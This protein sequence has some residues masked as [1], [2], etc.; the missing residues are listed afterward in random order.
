MVR[1]GAVPGDPAGRAA[2]D[3]V[4]LV[5]HGVQCGPLHAEQGP[6]VRLGHA[7]RPQH[8]P[9]PRHVRL[10]TQVVGQDVVA[11]T[12]IARSSAPTTMP[13]RSLPAV[14]CTRIGPGAVATSPMIPAIS[15]A[16]SRVRCR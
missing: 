7:G 14:Q 2:R 1:I 11:A 5:E 4:D 10:G 15:A 8:G 12:P 9:Q 6:V 13:V 16:A 3:G